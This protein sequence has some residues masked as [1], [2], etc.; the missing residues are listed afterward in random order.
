MARMRETYPELY[1]Q[2][3]YRRIANPTVQKLLFWFIVCW[4]MISHRTWDW[5]CVIGFRADPDLA[6]QCALIGVFL[7]HQYLGTFWGDVL[8]LVWPLVPVNAAVGRTLPA[9]AHCRG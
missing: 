5:I 6:R 1:E 9:V 2:V 3:A 4:E 8:L 7:F